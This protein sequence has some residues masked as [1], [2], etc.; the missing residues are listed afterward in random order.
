ML[1]KTH[2]DKTGREVSCFTSNYPGQAWFKSFMKRHKSALS[3]RMCQNIALKRAQI[4]AET[5][6]EYFS[7]LK[8]TL[9][10]I[11]PSHII[12]YDETSM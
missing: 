5:I 6:K 12:N 8:E 4:S 7:N 1:V 2:L 9:K 11:A 10:D 3:P